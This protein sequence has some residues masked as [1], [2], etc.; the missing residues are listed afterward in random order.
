MT[1][2]GLRPSRPAGLDHRRGEEAGADSAGAGRQMPRGAVLDR[3]EGRLGSH[4][5]HEWENCCAR[6]L[7]VRGAEERQAEF[8]DGGSEEGEVR[9]VFATF[10]A[11]ILSGL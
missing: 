3:H 1:G 10:L 7:R 9:Y 6:P 11:A 5:F 8:S 4:R 2:S